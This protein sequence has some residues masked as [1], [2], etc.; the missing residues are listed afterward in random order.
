MTKSAEDDLIPG[1]EVVTP[2]RRRWRISSVTRTGL[3]RHFL[4]LDL[5]QKRVLAGKIDRLAWNEAEQSWQLDGAAGPNSSPL[6][7]PHAAA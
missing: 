1:D 5:E 7:S 3:D 2:D 4:A 6:S